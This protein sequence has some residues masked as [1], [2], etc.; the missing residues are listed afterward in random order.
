MCAVKENSSSSNLSCSVVNTVA[1]F[2]SYL[3]WELHI[4]WVV[5][6]TKSIYICRTHNYTFRNGLQLLVL[7]YPFTLL[8]HLTRLQIQ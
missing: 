8:F 1:I 7:F 6:L 2:V 5:V 4:A 3:F